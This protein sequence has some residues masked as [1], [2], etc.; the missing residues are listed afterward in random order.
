MNLAR[1]F[2][3]GAPRHEHALY[4]SCAHQ[5]HARVRQVENDVT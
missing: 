4:A 2:V 3:C 1:P 5:S